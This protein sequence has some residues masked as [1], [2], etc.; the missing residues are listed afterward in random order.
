MALSN[1]P[2]GSSPLFKTIMDDFNKKDEI[3][4]PVNPIAQ[5][6]F[7][8]DSTNLVKGGLTQSIK[9][10]PKSINVSAITK[11]NSLFEGLEEDEGEVQCIVP[12]KNI[13]KLIVKPRRS[14]PSNSLTSD[15][16]SETSHLNSPNIAAKNK[17]KETAK[18]L[19][20]SVKYFDKDQLTND[21][22]N[23]SED[24]DNIHHN[25]NRYPESEDRAT[26][27]SNHPAGIILNRPDYKTIPSLDELAAKVDEKGNCFVDEFSILREDYGCVTFYGQTNVA[28]LNLDDIVQIRRKEICVY[29]DDTKKPNVGEGLN[30]EAEVSLHRVW[31][32]DK[33]THRPIIDP[34][35]LMNMRYDKRIEK[36][37]L[38]MDAEYI[39]Y[40]YETGTWTFKVK[41]FS[42]YSLK[43]D[44]SDDDENLNSNETDES[45]NMLVKQIQ[46][47]KQRRLELARKKNAQFKLPVDNVSEDYNSV[48]RKSSIEETNNQLYPDL[49]GFDNISKTRKLFPN[50]N[51]FDGDSSSKQKYLNNLGSV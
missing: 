10:T 46:L 19:E 44:D 20:D 41:H 21:Y 9:L 35:K 25:D 14:S 27:V 34:V 30:K 16:M 43:E 3:L 11:S 15:L 31:P 18:Y 39:D 42:I 24:G 6:S 23:I 50:L 48:S 4:K 33:N 22:T 8:T 7:M 36:Q 2:Y 12:R 17:E 1:S 38:Q 37:T 13:K 28:N 51:N 5:K 29:P 49:R 47:I 40:N 32:I 26:S 45:K